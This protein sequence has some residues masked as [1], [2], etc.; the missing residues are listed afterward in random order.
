MGWSC[1]TQTNI[2][3]SCSRRVLENHERTEL[4]ANVG[5]FSY[6]Q[7]LRRF[8]PLLSSPQLSCLC[9]LLFSSRVCSVSPPRHLGF[10]IVAVVVV[11]AAA[12]HAADG[13]CAS[14]VLL[15]VE[16]ILN[17]FLLLFFPRFDYFFFLFQKNTETPANIIVIITPAVD[18]SHLRGEREK[19]REEKNTY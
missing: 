18:T 7:I 16:A 1:I 3:H 13:K 17:I 5:C 9:L 8:T 19:E 6:R 14:H 11:V 2:S 12:T 10:A 15:F 4:N